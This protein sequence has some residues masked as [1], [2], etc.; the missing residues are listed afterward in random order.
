MSCVSDVVI[1]FW[2]AHVGQIHYANFLEVNVAQLFVQHDKDVGLT[3]SPSPCYSKTEIAIK[4]MDTDLMW[5]I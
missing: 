5:L 1:C 3:D 4:Y 2:W